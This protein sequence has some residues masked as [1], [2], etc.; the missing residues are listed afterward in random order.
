MKLVTF[1]CS[2]VYGDELIPNTP[3]YLNQ[4]NIGGVINKNYNFDE[5]VNYGNNGASNDRIVLQLLEYITSDYYDVN[6]FIVVGLSGLPRNI[7]Y[8]NNGKYPLTIPHWSY[9][10]HIRPSQHLVKDYEGCEDWMRLVFEFETNDRNDLVK[11]FL[12]ISTI[13]SLLLQFK[14][15][16]VFQSMD[17][18]SK[19]YDSV[20]KNKKDW[21]EIVIH[22]IY[23]NK[24][25]KKNSDL[26]FNENLVKKI[27]NNDLTKTQIWIN[28]LKTSY[29]G[30]INTNDEYRKHG[31]HP[32]ELGA[33]KYFEQILKNY[34]DKI[35]K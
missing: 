2:F 17:D 13:K 32:S 8:L 4:H 27:I 14:K 30:F 11:Y 22:H 18:P 35:I 29:Q 34:I 6:D 16:F 26:F 7:K 21:G 23:K 5:Y 1:G 33:E 31:G 19:V 20:N 10:D 12:N 9:I 15:H 24:E 28:F 25:Y 3:E